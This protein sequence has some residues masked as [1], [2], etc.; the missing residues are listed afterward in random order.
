MKSVGA[1]VGCIRFARR[2][3]WYGSQFFMFRLPRIHT[4]WMSPVV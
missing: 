3:R 4:L 1:C 2:V